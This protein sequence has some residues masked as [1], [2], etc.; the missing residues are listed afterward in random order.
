MGIFV[1]CHAEESSSPALAPGGK[2]ATKHLN[3]CMEALRSAYIVPISFD[4]VTWL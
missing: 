4:R 2:C 1:F 3:L